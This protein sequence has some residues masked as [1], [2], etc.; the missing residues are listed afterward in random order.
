MPFLPTDKQAKSTGPL[1]CN[2]REQRDGLVP[3]RAVLCSRRRPDVWVIVLQA[4]GHNVRIDVRACH[5]KKRKG[6]RGLF[7]G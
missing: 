1:P 3:V 2:M 5:A 4:G 7:P 6:K